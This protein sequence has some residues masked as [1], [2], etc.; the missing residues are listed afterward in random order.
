MAGER[1]KKNFS[2]MLGRKEG[3]GKIASFRKADITSINN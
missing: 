3:E 2:K 1:K